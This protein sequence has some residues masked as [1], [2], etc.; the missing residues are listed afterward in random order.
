MKR[1]ISPT[2]IEN[3][4]EPK[5]IKQNSHMQQSNRYQYSSIKL[6]ESNDQKNSILDLVDGILQPEND[7]QEEKWREKLNG[8]LLVDIIPALL[9][10]EKNGNPFRIRFQKCC[11][12]LM[13]HIGHHKNLEEYLM[14]GY[15]L[16]DCTDDFHLKWFLKKK[17]YC[18]ALPMDM[19][20]VIDISKKER[21]VDYFWT[22]Y[23]HG[24]RE[25]MMI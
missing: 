21:Y 24:S 13:E 5:K 18:M 10:S 8:Y 20:D 12:E 1:T 14:N 6:L 17:H 22:C 19:F 3:K 23:L 25:T 11:T 16:D 9:F 15:D 4:K 2:K 7:E